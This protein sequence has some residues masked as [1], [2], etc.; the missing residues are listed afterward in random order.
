MTTERLGKL[1]L[2]DLD[3]QDSLIKISGDDEYGGET[4]VGR[5]TG[6]CG[7]ESTCLLG[8]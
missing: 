7:R 4:G 1:A 3:G 6:R 5:G 2:S 8:S